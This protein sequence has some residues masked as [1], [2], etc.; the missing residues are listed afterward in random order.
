MRARARICVCIPRFARSATRAAISTQRT[1]T[2]SITVYA[3][4][5]G[6]DRPGA[7]ILLLLLKFQVARASPTGTTAG[8]V[9]ATIMPNAPDIECRC[10]ASASRL[11]I[12]GPAEEERRGGEAVCPRCSFASGGI[13]E[14]IRVKPARN[15]TERACRCWPLIP[16]KV[17]SVLPTRPSS[18][19]PCFPPSAVPQPQTAYIIPAPDRRLP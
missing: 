13:T 6:R 16:A 3:G 12:Y 8:I 15:G 10:G 7:A 17:C 2:A 1:T 11:A 4:R 5:G 9:A 14:G 18:R 19:S